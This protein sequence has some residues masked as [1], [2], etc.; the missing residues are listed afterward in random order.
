MYHRWVQHNI[1]FQF[2]GGYRQMIGSSW[3]AEVKLGGGYQI[4]IPDSKVY[5]I[6]E[7]DGLVREHLP[8]RSQFIGNLG[9]DISKDLKPPYGPRI[10]MEYQQRL[11]IPFVNAYVPILPYNNLLIG[12]EIPMR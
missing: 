7:N 1:S 6:T 11:Q 12:I 3:A 4:T 10:F 2:Q 9:F 8:L 5:R